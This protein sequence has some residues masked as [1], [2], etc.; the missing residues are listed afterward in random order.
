[1][2]RTSYGYF[3]YSLKVG[4]SIKITDLLWLRGKDL[5]R[6]AVPG[7]RCGLT[8]ILAFSDRCGKSGAASSATGSA[9]PLFQRPPPEVAVSSF[10]Q[11]KRKETHKASLSFWL[12]GKDLNLPGY[13]Y[14]NISDVKP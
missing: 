5:V 9:A 4:N 8:L 13:F 1:M 11:A 6:L 3:V 12:R 14:S 10:L 7:K 2:L